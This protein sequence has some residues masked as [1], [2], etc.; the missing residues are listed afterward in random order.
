MICN[1]AIVYGAA[2]GER[3]MSVNCLRTPINDFTANE[4]HRGRFDTSNIL[5]PCLV[6]YSI[7]TCARIHAKVCHIL[8]RYTV[9]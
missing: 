1:R 8:V 4:L 3:I 7:M 5:G 2:H 9:G 6:I